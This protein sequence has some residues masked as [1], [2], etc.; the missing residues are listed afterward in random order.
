MLKLSKVN[1]KKDERLILNNIDLEIEKGHFYGIIGPNGSGKSTLLDAIIGYKTINSGDIY[2][3]NKKMTEY[4]SKEYGKK[5]SLVPQEFDTYFSYRTMEI[6]EMGRYPYKGEVGE[7]KKGR[8]IIE[9][10]IKLFKLEGLLEKN[11]NEMSGGEKQRILF[12]K[13]LVQDTD[14]I[15][16]DEATSNLDPYNAHS[17]MLE[18]K[19]EIKEQ[20]KGVVAVLHD[21]NLAT[22]YCD[23]IIML[24]DG[25]IIENST[26][27]TGITRDKIHELFMVESEILE[28]KGKKIV[29]SHLNPN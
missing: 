15:F 23:K 1:Y 8:K 14:Y 21:I 18:I 28:S 3:D 10:F 27:D 12:V 4:T 26:I 9:K 2:I 25:K 11:I 13:A 7:D 22:L 29:F 16:L 6:L 20:Q 5:I 24:K 19:R 17:L